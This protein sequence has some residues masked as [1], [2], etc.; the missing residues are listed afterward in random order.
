VR[1]RLDLANAAPDVQ[2]AVAAGDIPVSKAKEITKNSDGSIDKQKEALE[3]ARQSP[4]IKRQVIRFVDGNAIMTGFKEDHC[5]PI[6][7]L[8]NDE[9]FIRA[10]KT[11]GF[12]PESIKIS[13]EPIVK[14]ER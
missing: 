3:K 7:D 1:N 14:D 8:V 5:E 9:K 10:I 12:N 11:A 2:A 6:L 4:K 13:I